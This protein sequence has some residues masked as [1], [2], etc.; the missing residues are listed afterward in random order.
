MSS[1]ETFQA[2]T[3]AHQPARVIAR[4]VRNAADSGYDAETF[5]AASPAW[6]PATLPAKQSRVIKIKRGTRLPL[7]EWGRR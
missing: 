3:K 2:F 5:S 6:P 1:L 4:L 7:G